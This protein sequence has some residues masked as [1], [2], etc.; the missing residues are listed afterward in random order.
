MRLLI[1][2]L[3]IALSLAGCADEAPPTLDESEQGFEELGGEVTETTGLIR[4]IVLDPAIVPIEGVT[5]KVLSLDLETVTN[6]DGAFVFDELE[7]GTYFLEISKIGYNTTQAA[8]DV[9]AGVERPPAVKIQLTPNPDSVPYVDS[10]QNRGYL[11]CS[12]SAVNACGLVDVILCIAGS[13]E[14]LGDQFSVTVG[15]TSPPTWINSEMVWQSTQALGQNLDFYLD[16][17]VKGDDVSDSHIRSVAGPSPLLL[18]VDAEEADANGMGT[19]HDLY[20][21]IF[22]QLEDPTSAVFLDQAFDVYSHVF[23]NYMPYDGWRIT[24]DGTVPAPPS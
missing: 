19:T 18:T 1:T 4:G 21:R 22:P 8:A 10:F 14:F 2:T 5:V 7:E 20:H 11:V 6:E 24:E 23:Y 16:T 3:L 9:Q 12:T 13:C 17:T 15:I